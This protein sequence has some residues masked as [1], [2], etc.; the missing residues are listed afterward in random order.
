MIRRVFV[1]FYIV[2]GRFVYFFISFY[3]DNKYAVILFDEKV[4]AEFTSF[5]VLSLFPGVLNA[6][7][8]NRSILNPCGDFGGK[9][10]SPSH[11][12]VPLIALRDGKPAK[13]SRRWD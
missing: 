9:W 7:E 8:S 5:R 2:C 1:L 11:T 13:A 10:V 12:S 4:R 6:I 3:L